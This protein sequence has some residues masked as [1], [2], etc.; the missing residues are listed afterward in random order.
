MLTTHARRPHRS[1]GFRNIAASACAMMAALT[2]PGVT[3]SVAAED[4][5]PPPYD[6][7]MLSD[8]TRDVLRREAAGANPSV[9]EPSRPGGTKGPKPEPDSTGDNTEPAETITVTDIAPAPEGFTAPI[10]AGARERQKL[11]PD[12]LNPAGYQSN[13]WRQRT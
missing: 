5:V 3:P 8:I 9:A 13:S 10:E 2:S 11:S 7:R 6:R 4:Q 12:D 1:L